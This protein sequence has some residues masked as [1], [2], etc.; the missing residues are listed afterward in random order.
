[1]LLAISSSLRRVRPTS[2]RK[3]PPGVGNADELSALD[4]PVVQDLPASASTCRDHLEV[5]IQHACT[6][7]VSDVSGLAMVQQ[8]GSASSGYSSTR[9]S[10][11][12][13][14]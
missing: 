12:Q 8:A 10:R 5:Y 1:M 7:P 6:Q 11:D 4:I 13:S 14:F 3:L 2:P 9:A